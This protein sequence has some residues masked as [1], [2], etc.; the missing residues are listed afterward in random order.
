MHLDESEKKYVEELTLLQQNK[1]SFPSVEFPFLILHFV[2]EIITS[3][4]GLGSFFYV[5]EEK[6]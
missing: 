6:T 1:P 3:L 2:R 5:L 4:A